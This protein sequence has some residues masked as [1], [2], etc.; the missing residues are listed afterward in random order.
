MKVDCGQVVKL[1]AT[2]SQENPYRR[3]GIFK[4]LKLRG[5]DRN[6][7]LEELRRQS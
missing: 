3:R 6:P 1:V 4:T 7:W 2:P 5:F